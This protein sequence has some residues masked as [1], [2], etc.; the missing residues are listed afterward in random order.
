MFGG[1]IYSILIMF[2]YYPL[3]GIISSDIYLIGA[4]AVTGLLYLAIHSWLKKKGT[5][6]FA[7]L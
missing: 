7:E 6:I 2:A 3:S 4:A 1:W 5:K